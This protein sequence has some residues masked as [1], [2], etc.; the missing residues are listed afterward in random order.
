MKRNQEYARKDNQKNQ[1]DSIGR[2]SENK[3]KEGREKALPERKVEKA[4]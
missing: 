4:I 1:E 3:R 2:G